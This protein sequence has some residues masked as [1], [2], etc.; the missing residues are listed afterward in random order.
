M[1]E[2]KTQD[3]QL[4]TV[5]GIMKDERICMLTSTAEDGA[6]HAHPMTTQDAE[7]D[8]DSWFILSAESETARN[9]ATRPQVNLG[10]AGSGAWLS[11]AGTAEMVENEEKKEEL[12]NPFVEA[13]FPNGKDDTNIRIM[14]VRGDEAHYWDSPGKVAMTLSMLTS[15]VTKNPP[16]SGDSGTVDLDA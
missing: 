1:S 9:I 5:R 7:Y 10:Y 15:A 6:L 16:S 8:G 13:W 2:N 14:R 11:I 4:E 12:W 3:E